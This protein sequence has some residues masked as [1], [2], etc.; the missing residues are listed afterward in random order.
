M[1]ST[2]TPYWA[3]LISL[4]LVAAVAAG[5]S[6]KKNNDDDGGGP[7]PDTEITAVEAA[8]DGLT[9]T[10]MYKDKNDN[11]DVSF[12]CQVEQTQAEKG[13]AP[14]WTDCDPA[15]LIVDVSPQG[16][17][18]FRVKAFAGGIEDLSPASR[19]YVA[20]GQAPQGA[21]ETQQFGAII[22]NKG[23]LGS[24]YT[25]DKVS[26]HFGVSG[27]VKMEDIRFEYDQTGKGWER[28]S[29][30]SA[31]ILTM[32][33]LVDGAEYQVAVRAVNKATNAIGGVD[34]V[35]FSVKLAGAVSV[36]SSMDL[37]ANKTGTAQLSLAAANGEVS[38]TSCAL[39]GAAAG[40]CAEYIPTLNLD[41]MAAGS[42]RLVVQALDASGKSLGSTTVNFCA[43]S[44]VTASRPVVAQPQIMS[45]GDFYSLK[46]PDGMHVTEY[47][48][49]KNFTGGTTGQLQFYRIRSNSDPFYI[50]N[51]KCDGNFDTIVPSSSPRGQV[52]DYCYSTFPRT[53]A[54]EFYKWLTS[55]GLANNHIEI[56]SDADKITNEEHERIV[57][58]VFDRDYEFMHGRS[59]FEQLCMN[60]RGEIVQTP[61]IAW[62]DNFWTE[63]VRARMVICK[64]TFANSIAGNG[65]P[66]LDPEIWRNVWWVGSFFV[67]ST[68]EDLPR[69]ECFWNDWQS[70]LKHGNPVDYHPEFCGN[71]K[72]PSL[73]EVTYISKTPYPSAEWFAQEAQMRIRPI[74]KELTPVFQ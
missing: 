18:T 35:K 25:K 52:Y 1:K 39:D 28:T 23:D 11:S 33:D 72:N 43:Q 30:S 68:G 47:S 55:Y 50:G 53:N 69:N 51:Y 67:D 65:L 8:D 15:G 16:R 42:H 19:V 26:L 29:A 34:S 64:V 17:Y 31:D 66:T 10:V 27:N 46:I 2:L 36:T 14:E 6:K 70:D 63:R 41:E 7:N 74:L 32:T 9:V 60:A 57:L 54:D 5:C 4:S 24:V 21:A 22:L 48:S 61:N 38:T 40:S 49:T 59:R 45:L 71:F 13:A 20:K 37:T 62:I 56:A 44:C 58:N 12:K 73:L 3:Q